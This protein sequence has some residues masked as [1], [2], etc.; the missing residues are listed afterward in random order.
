MKIQYD[1]DSVYKNTNIVDNKYLDI[2]E[3]IISDVTIYDLYSLTLESKY[4]ERPDM[5]AYDYRG[6]HSMSTD[7]LA[8]DLFSNA[9]LWWIFAEFN[10]DLL[11]DPIIDFKS[12]LTIQ[13]PTDFI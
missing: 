8:Y 4:N 12:G 5:L 9:N 3:P 11:K 6:V 1:T 10:Q 2:M 7:M 13:V